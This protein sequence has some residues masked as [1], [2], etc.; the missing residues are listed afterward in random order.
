MDGAEGQGGFRISPWT[1]EFAERGAECAYRERIAPSMSRFARVT[2]A[3]AAVFFLAFAYSDVLAL[4]WRSTALVLVACRATVA[5]AGLLVVIRLAR[6]PLAVTTGVPVSLFEA[7]V[8]AAFGLVIWY[9]TDAAEI[10]GVSIV[11]MLSAVYFFLPNRALNSVL[12]ALAGTAAFLLLVRVRVAMPMSHQVDLLLLLVLVNSFGIVG[13]YRL[14]RVARDQFRLLSM[15]ERANASLQREVAARRDLE[16]QLQLLATTDDLTGLNNRRQYLRRSAE[17]LVGADRTG[18]PVSVLLMDLDHFKRIND[19][20]GHETGDAALRAVAGVLHRELRAT[21]LAARYGGEEF[22]VTLPDSDPERGRT[23][24]ERIRRAI[25]GMSIP[26][27]P[28][29]LGATV[30]IGIAV[31]TGGEDLESLLRAADSAL[32][33]GKDAGRNRVAV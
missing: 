3:L 18:N 17:I 10:F 21:D 19:S 25:E 12:V 7:L 26:G 15:A 6:R 1:A 14:S 16:Q 5:V 33:R 8:F 28:A 30:T 23:V 32:Y 22:A 11:A 29:G 31:R 2:V 9:R 13:S 27:A 24:A 20:F 4:G